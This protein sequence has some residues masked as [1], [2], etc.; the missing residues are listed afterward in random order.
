LLIA[1]FYFLYAGFSQ[2]NDVRN[3]EEIMKNLSPPFES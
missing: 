2:Q 3:M 1:F